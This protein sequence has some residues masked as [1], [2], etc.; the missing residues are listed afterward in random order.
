MADVVINTKVE[1]PDTSALQAIKKELKEMKSLSLNGD[2]VA[3][4]RVAE[5]TD[6]LE[7]LKMPPSH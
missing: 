1:A 6:K 3:A 2:G 4:K 7:D 5:L